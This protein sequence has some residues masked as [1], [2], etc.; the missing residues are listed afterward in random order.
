MKVK[1]KPAAKGNVTISGIYKLS[2]C[3]AQNCQ[4]E[5]QELSA[6]VAVK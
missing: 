3:S 5:S 4:L 1:F 6:T 2:V